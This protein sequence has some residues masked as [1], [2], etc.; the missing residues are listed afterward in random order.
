MTVF[1]AK[2][3][4]GYGAPWSSP[5]A[6]PVD[7]SLDQYP[8]AQKHTDSYVCLVQTLRYPNGP[9]VTE[10]ITEAFWKV[11]GRRCW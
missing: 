4:Y 2:N 11:A 5:H 1:Q 9:E 6:E 7:Y 10:M 8:V 3:A